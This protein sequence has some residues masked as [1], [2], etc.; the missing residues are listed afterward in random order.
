MISERLDLVPAPFRTWAD[1]VVEPDVVVV[2][3]RQNLGSTITNRVKDLPPVP[4]T[5]PSTP[6][7]TPTATPTPT[8][9]VP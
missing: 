8:E 5:Q 7:P 2:A 1:P 4:P 3:K 6:T 9:E